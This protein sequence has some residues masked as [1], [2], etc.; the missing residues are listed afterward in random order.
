MAKLLMHLRGVPEDEAN[1]VRELLR[2][3][4]ADFYET[5]PNR[6][7]LSMGAIWL[8]D[9]SDYE[10]VCRLLDSYQRQRAER[11]RMALAE[12]QRTG[13]QETLISLFLRDPVRNVLYVCL[14]VVIVYFSITPFMAL[15]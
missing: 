10:R 9:E 8:R 14:V 6:W 1:E 4:A 13:T 2:E 15:M 12:Q 11:A 5:P 3:H 7:G